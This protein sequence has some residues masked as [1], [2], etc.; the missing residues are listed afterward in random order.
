MK[1]SDI[2]RQ[3]ISLAFDT[4]PDPTQLRLSDC[5]DLLTRIVTS[6]Q[7]QGRLTRAV[8]H[9]H[10]LFAGADPEPP[11]TEPSTPPPQEPPAVVEEPGWVKTGGRGSLEKK[12]VFDRLAAYRQSNGLGCFA[13]IVSAANGAVSEQDL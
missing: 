1:D 12:A 6:E 4:D 7:K 3:L 10:A 2:L 13:K 5:L 9:Q 11:D 8:T